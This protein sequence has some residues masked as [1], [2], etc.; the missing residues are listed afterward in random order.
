MRGAKL[1]RGERGSAKRALQGT[2]DH[3]E[4]WMWEGPLQR[5]CVE[6]MWAG[7]DKT[8]HLGTSLGGELNYG[9]SQP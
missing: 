3:K 1:D 6:A 5:A 9:G 4:L 8:V 7:F 2:H